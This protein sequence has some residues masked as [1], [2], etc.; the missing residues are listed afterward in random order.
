MTEDF[1]KSHTSGADN[2]HTV[3]PFGKPKKKERFVQ[4]TFCT[5]QDHMNNGRMS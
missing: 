3:L 2:A 1:M 5:L 4:A